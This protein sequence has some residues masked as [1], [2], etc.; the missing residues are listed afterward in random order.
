M[1]LLIK[2]NCNFYLRH[3]N[4]LDLSRDTVKRSIQNLIVKGLYIFRQIIVTSFVSGIN[5]EVY[6]KKV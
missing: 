5:F 6:G 1:G 2:K 4:Q 3:L